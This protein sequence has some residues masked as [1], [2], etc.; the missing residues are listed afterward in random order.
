MSLEMQIKPFFA[1]NMSQELGSAASTSYQL[2]QN[3]NDFSIAF[4]NFSER[5]FT[6]RMISQHICTVKAINYVNF[7]IKTESN[8]KS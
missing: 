7:H 5:L 6:L 4:Y 2:C 1:N 8:D 3:N